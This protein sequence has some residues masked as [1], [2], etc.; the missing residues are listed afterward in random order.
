MC[1]EDQTRHTGR[2]RW[3][4]RCSAS[5]QVP[6]IG[7]FALRA[8]QIFASH[9]TLI[10]VAIGFDRPRVTRDASIC[11]CSSGNWSGGRLALRLFVDIADARVV[12]E[13]GDAFRVVRLA[14]PF[15]MRDH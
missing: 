11:F 6:A 8:V 3:L 9:A 10:A 7:E 5:L 4:W 13:K 12:A 2:E 14:F 1:R 15:D